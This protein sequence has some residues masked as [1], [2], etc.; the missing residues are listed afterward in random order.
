MSDYLPGY[1]IGLAVGAI[2]FSPDGTDVQ[3]DKDTP[4]LCAAYEQ[5]VDQLHPTFEKRDLEGAIKVYGPDGEEICVIDQSNSGVETS[6]TPPQT[7]S[8]LTNTM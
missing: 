6:R 4:D 1:L 2:I 8:D 3:I 7:A 5:V